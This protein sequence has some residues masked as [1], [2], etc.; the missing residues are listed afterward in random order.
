[1]NGA[2]SAGNSFEMG[3]NDL[4][5]YLILYIKISTLFII[6]SVKHKTIKLLK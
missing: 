2:G 1:M 4:D 6:I 3:K 5:N